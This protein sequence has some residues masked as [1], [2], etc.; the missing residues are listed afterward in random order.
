MPKTAFNPGR[1]LKQARRSRKIRLRQAARDLCIR[2]EL[3]QALENNKTDA[4]DS[5]AYAIGFMRSYAGYLGLDCEPF[6]AY[7]KDAIA[8]EPIPADAL[9][10]QESPRRLW[11]SAFAFIVF[12]GLL[13]S[14]AFLGWQVL[15]ANRTAEQEAE[16][17][18]QF[19][20]LSAAAPARQVS[21]RPAALLANGTVS[22]F[23]DLIR[24][25]PAEVGAVRMLAVAEARVAIQ[26]ES[27]RVLKE[28]VIYRGESLELPLSLGI[29]VVTPDTGA[30]A[31]FSGGRRALV[32]GDADDGLIRYSL[33][34]M[35]ETRSSPAALNRH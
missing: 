31:F 13:G 29:E 10:L 24:E 5:R 19:A 7:L 23:R 30:L 2:K 12:M 32:L 9:P 20:S 6:V 27:G 11:L 33:D 25:S 18:A 15:E 22:F 26:D 3:L 1:R 14:A 28:G 8:P 4:F 21:Q 34:E 35:A 16:R 17:P